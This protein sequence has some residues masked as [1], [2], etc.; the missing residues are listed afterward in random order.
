[1]GADRQ[2][3]ERLA[4][5]KHA[6][7]LDSASAK[8]TQSL[9]STTQ[10]A[11]ILDN[12]IALIIRITLLEFHCLV[13][14]NTIHEIKEWAPVVVHRH[15]NLLRRLNGADPKGYVPAGGAFVQSA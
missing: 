6:P 9:N 12:I 3:P 11:T 14:D 5:C 2:V 4:A 10:L 13:T 8:K 7:F 15:G 1:L